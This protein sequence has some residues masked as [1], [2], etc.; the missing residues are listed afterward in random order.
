MPRLPRRLAHDQPADIVE[1]L[2]ELRTRLVVCVVAVAAGF[3][4]AYT[5][6]GQLLDA[7]GR[8]LP[9]EHRHPITLGVAEPFVTTMKLC[10]VAGFGLALPIVLWQVWSYLAPAFQRHVQRTLAAFVAAAT[11]LFAGG[12][13]FGYRVAL[14]A[15]VHF[16]TAYDEQHYTILVRAQD[17]Y[18]FAI[19]VLAAVGLVFELP[20]FI[21]GLVRLHVL[22]AAT[23]RRRRRVGYAIVAALAVA[24]PGVDP[25]TTAIEMVPLFL[26]FE[27]SIWLAVLFDHRHNTARKTS[28]ALT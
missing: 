7:L 9:V 26:L 4:V 22:S 12:V 27:A 1:H 28:T 20:V 23:L 10:L 3:A 6:H 15:A 14:P 11:L 5:L 21:I 18:S 16:L 17:Y 24:L 8:A 2:D 25:V 13:A 19:M